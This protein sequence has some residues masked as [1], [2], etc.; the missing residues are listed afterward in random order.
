MLQLKIGKNTTKK[1]KIIND[2]IKIFNSLFTYSIFKLLHNKN[3]KI[4]INKR[5]IQH[6]QLVPSIKLNPLIKTMKKKVHT[7]ILV[8][9]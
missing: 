5:F 1:K 2:K 3:I 4:F 9:S 7:K 6:K 8:K